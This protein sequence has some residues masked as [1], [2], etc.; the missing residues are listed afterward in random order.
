MALTLERTTIAASPP[1][2]QCD[3]SDAVAG[4]EQRF[5]D[6]LGPQRDDDRH[7]LEPRLSVQRFCQP[8]QV[9]QRHSHH[10]VV[11]N[12]VAGA[13]V[14]ENG[15]RTSRLTPLDTYLKNKN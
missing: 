9:W 1:S 12:V 10:V 5:R 15:R 2:S 7:V 14:A 6:A 13:R 11:E 8:V 3:G 4:S